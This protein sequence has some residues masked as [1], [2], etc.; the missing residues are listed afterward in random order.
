MG[1]YDFSK[2]EQTKV[3]MKV[4]QQQCAVIEFLLFEG[5]RGEEITIGL[6]IVYG[7]AAN[8]RSTVF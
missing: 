5:R 8:S 2:A 1:T 4:K 7:E 3:S 6:H